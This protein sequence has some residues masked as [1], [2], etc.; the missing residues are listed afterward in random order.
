MP[1]IVKHLEAP[2]ENNLESKEDFIED[3]FF[4]SSYD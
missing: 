3:P 2:G 4:S 1:I